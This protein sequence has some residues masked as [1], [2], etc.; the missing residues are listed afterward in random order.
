MKSESIA[1]CSILQHFQKFA[2][3]DRTYVTTPLGDQVISYFE[4]LLKGI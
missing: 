2:L 4:K 1:N 3:P